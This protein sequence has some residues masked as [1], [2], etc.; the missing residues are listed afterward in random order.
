MKKKC[1]KVNGANARKL[2]DVKQWKQKQKDVVFCS[3]RLDS[4]RSLVMNDGCIQGNYMQGEN[5]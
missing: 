4:L 2:Q 1:S 3:K 5:M